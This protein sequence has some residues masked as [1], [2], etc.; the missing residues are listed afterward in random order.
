MGPGV[1][2]HM[3]D[4]HH[5]EQTESKPLTTELEVLA[6]EA[7]AENN[8]LSSEFTPNQQ[9][10]IAQPASSETSADTQPSTVAVAAESAEEPDYDAADFAEALANFDREQAAESAAAQS[11][12]ADEAVVTDVV[13]VV[14]QRLK[15]LKL[16][17]KLLDKP[18]YQ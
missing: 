4:N 16:N 10:E 5:S 12:T 17:L 11:L 9:H 2:K 14:E 15:L 1:R 6:P 7:T 18:H 3:V 13:V 8:E